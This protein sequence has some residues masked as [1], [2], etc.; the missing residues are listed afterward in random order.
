MPVNQEQDKYI[1]I[2]PKGP[3]VTILLYGATITSWK[4]PD[5]SGTLQDRLFV[6]SKAKLDGTQPVRGGIPVVFPCFGAPVHPD[7][8][9]LPQHGFARK[10]TWSY[11]STVMDNEAGVSVRFVLNPNETIQAV[12]PKAFRLF[13]VVTLAEHQLST[14]IHVENTSQN[15][16]L[17]F[18]ALLHTYI[19]APADQV[20][21][22][23]LQGLKFHDKTDPT[24]EGRATLQEESRS[25]VDVRKFTD[26]VYIDGPGKYDVSWPGGGME[27]KAVNLKDVV[28]WNPQEE[29]VKIG[30]MESD[31]WKRYVCV[32]PGHVGGFIS[33][34]PGKTWIG[35]Q[36]L[37]V[38]SG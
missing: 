16:L 7:H 20:I 26:S 31:G 21:V 11:D 13:Y 33:L 19:R 37:T 1:L 10:E 25:A 2:H 23:P 15:D 32:E 28:V 38:K 36:V 6:S 12:F 34:E 18:Q 22:A 17:T 35:Q 3:T 24:P 5:N 8:Q 29:G 27:V 30:D 14:D 4:V 9:K